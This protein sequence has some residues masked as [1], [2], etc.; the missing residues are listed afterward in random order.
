[1]DTIFTNPNS[2]NIYFKNVSFEYDEEQE[3]DF[4]KIYLVESCYADMAIPTRVALVMFKSP[5]IWQ[6]MDESYSVYDSYEIRDDGGPIQI[7][8]RSKYLDFVKTEYP[9]YE[10]I[11]GEIMHIR[12]WSQNIVSEVISTETPSMEWIYAQQS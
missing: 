10:A 6:H 3:H 1:M 2:N 8:E 9:Q 4:L 5:L 7:L 12:V 11:R